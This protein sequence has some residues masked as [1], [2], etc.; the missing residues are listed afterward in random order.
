MGQSTLASAV[1]IFEVMQSAGWRLESEQDL[2]D[3]LP[4]PPQ[5]D[6]QVGRFVRNGDSVSISRVTY[7]DPI[8]ANPHESWIRERMRLMPEANERVVRNGATVV[9]IIAQ[10]GSTADEVMELFERVVVQDGSGSGG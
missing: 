1:D 7:P 3:Y 2:A 6:G 9:H 4:V 8:F 5:S 10:S